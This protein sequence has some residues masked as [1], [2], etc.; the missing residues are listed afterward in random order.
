MIEDILITPLKIIETPGGNVMHAMKVDDLG[1]LNF[2]EAYF[3]IIN[4][5]KIKAWKRHREMTFNLVV[6]FGKVRFVLFDDREGR[7][8]IFQEFVISKD[9]YCR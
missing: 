8:G 6:P 4:S 3:S 7:R 5:F 1:Y 2:G 9:N